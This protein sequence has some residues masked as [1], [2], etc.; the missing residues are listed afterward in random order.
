MENRKYKIL[1][2]SILDKIREENVQPETPV[3]SEAEL[4]LQ[5]GFSR[6][7]IRQALKELELE[8]YLYRVKGKGTFIRSGTG[9]CSRKIALFLRQVSDMI[10]PVTAEM[11]HGLNTELEKKGYFLDILT[12]ARDFYSENLAKLSAQYAGFI[13]ASRIQDPRTLAEL[14]KLSI[15]HLAV[16]NYDPSSGILAVR[17]DFEQGGRM[18]AEHLIDRGCKSLGLL[19]P[20]E[21][22]Q[23]AAE[24]RKGV[25]ETALEA[26]VRMKRVYQ[27]AT[28]GYSEE[29]ARILAEKLV[30]SDDLPDGLICASDEQA[31]AI[32]EV[33]RNHKI[34]V[35]DDILLT[36][37]NDLVF[38]RLM[39]PSLTTIHFPFEECGREAGEKILA[40]IHGEN[41]ESVLLHPELIVREST[42]P[43][44]QKKEKK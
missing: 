35:P 6:N 12:G 4:A 26:G 38:T 37:C 3:P 44:S 29:E 41:P 42:E 21:S 16:K 32:L 28:E 33:F 18:I 23:I 8:G 22:L 1:K 24:F 39:S 20:G 30:V 2:Q 15:P 31:L 40:M 17:L 36:G 7:T 34:R 19:C 25:C 13:L 5:Y 9:L 11:I 43:H 27:Q 14:H 10:H